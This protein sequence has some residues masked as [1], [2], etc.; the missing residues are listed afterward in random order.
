VYGSVHP[1]VAYNLDQRAALAVY[2]NNL[3]RAESLSILAVAAVGSRSPSPTR[4]S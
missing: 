3:A 2:L 4:C 1:R